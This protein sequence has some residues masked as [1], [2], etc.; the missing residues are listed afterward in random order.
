MRTAEKTL[1]GGRVVQLAMPDMYRVMVTIK[2][3]RAP[4]PGVAA[5]LRLLDGAGALPQAGLLQRYQASAEFYQGLYE[6]AALCLQSPR[7]RLD[8]KEGEEAGP[9]EITPNDLTW[10][11]LEIIY[12]TFFRADPAPI[13][14]GPDPEQISAAIAGLHA[15]GASLDDIAGFLE[16]I[17]A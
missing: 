3:G 10:Q 9:D 17:A 8:L 12:Y 13:S 7:L 2:S 15:G 6:I 5:V 1:S 16:R 11:D 4:N 14:A